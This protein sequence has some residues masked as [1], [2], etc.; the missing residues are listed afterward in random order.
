MPVM[1]GL[2]ATRKIRELPDGKEVKI[3]ALTASVFKEQKNEVLEA[4]SDDF[5]RKPY[6]PEEI[7]DSVARHLG[8]KYI[9]PEEIKPPPEPQ[10]DTDQ[11]QAA[12][13][14]LPAEL[15]GKLRQAAR[16]LNTAKMA[17]LLEQT[18][19]HDDALAHAL[20]RCL[21]AFDFQTIQE[22]LSPGGDED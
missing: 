17:D 8:V 13:A 4:G 16:E 22:V 2:T 10:M 14:R 1:N 9:Y 21:D 19:G 20:E 6:R 5:V 12:A 15:A 7:F 11:L 3:A 18:A